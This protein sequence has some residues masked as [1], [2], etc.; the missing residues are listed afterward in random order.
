M[1]P[2]F[3]DGV[4]LVKRMLIDALAKL[5]F[6]EV[7]ADGAFDPVLHNAVMQEE[8]EGKNPGEVLEVLQKGY[9]VKGR[10]LRHS[11]VKVAK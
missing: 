2:C 10:I 3:V 1:E 5:G 8:A 6:E 9:R 11:M 7:P 4:R